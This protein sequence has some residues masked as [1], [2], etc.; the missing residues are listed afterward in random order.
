MSPIRVQLK[1]LSSDG[2][3]YATDCANTENMFRIIRSIP[4]KKAEPF[5]R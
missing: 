2:K 1:L 4:S 5:K 3:K